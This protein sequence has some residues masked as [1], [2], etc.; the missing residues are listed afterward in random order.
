MEFNEIIKYLIDNLKIEISTDDQ[1]MCESNNQNVNVKL[2]IGEVVISEA[3]ATVYI[4]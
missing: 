3:E 2:L 4:D 1:G